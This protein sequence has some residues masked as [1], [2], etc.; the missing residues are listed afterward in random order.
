MSISEYFIPRTRIG[1]NFGKCGFRASLQIGCSANDSQN[2]QASRATF[3]SGS[4]NTWKKLK[5]FYKMI[6]Q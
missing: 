5:S 4:C 2:S 1:I 3:S 6:H